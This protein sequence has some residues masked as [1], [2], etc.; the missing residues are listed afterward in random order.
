MIEINKYELN[1]G[2]IC[3][4]KHNKHGETIQGEVLS[5]ED[6]KYQHILNGKECYDK[7]LSKTL[8]EN[9][10]IDEDIINEKVIITVYG[11]L[12]NYNWKIKEQLC[13]LKFSCSHYSIYK[14]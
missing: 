4:F 14:Y 12:K 3:L 6:Q 13:E 5:I 7:Y 11:W 8:Q 10:F 9:D 2:D 1:I